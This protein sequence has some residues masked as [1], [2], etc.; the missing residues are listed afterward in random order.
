MQNKTHYPSTF[1]L[2]LL[3]LSILF[4]VPITAILGIGSLI[5]LIRGTADAA[6]Q[7]IMAFAFGF[8]GLLLILCAWFV[9]EK[10]RHKESADASFT[11]PFSSWHIAAAFGIVTLGIAIGTAASLLENAFLSWFLLPILT[12]LVIVPPVWLIFGLGSHGLELGA[13]WRFFSIFGIGMTLAPLI[14][15]VLEI[16]VLVLGIFIGAVYIGI[17]QPDMFAEIKTVADQLSVVTDEQVMISLLAPY[18]ANTSLIIIGLSYI[19][20]IVPLIEELFKPLGVWLFGFQIE[21]PAQ[22]FV[23]GLLSGAGFA[24]FE[25]LNASADGSMSWGAIVTARA[26]TSLLHMTASGIMGWGIVSAFKEKKYGRLFGAYLAAVLIHGV[27]NA[28]AAGAG[29]SALGESIGRPEWLFTF[30]PALVCGLL[31]LAIG[32]FAV[33]IASNRKLRT[34]S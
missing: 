4:L 31:V 24:L 28:S 27:W 9:L 29:I 23:L 13:R 18:L 20:L 22:G 5:S 12:I 1:T 25:S 3:A 17:S 15:I 32:M 11:F 30:T 2:I 33:L 7:M 16:V 6:G 14:M 19:A 10:V 26:G 21:T 34:T 8:V